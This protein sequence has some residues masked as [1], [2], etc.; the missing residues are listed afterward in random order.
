MK[1]QVVDSGMKL[2]VAFRML[3]AADKELVEKALYNSA[4]KLSE[5]VGPKAEELADYIM[6]QLTDE[7]FEVNPKE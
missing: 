4:T 6:K 3:G 1:S 2:E 7:G 5:I